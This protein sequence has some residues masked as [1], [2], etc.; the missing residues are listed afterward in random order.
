MDWLWKEHP[1]LWPMHNG[2]GLRPGIGPVVS[3]ELLQ[4]FSESIRAF[5]DE[6]QYIYNE[7]ISVKSASLE[8][9]LQNE[10]E[11]RASAQQLG[12]AG[13]P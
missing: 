13:R 4:K 12:I 3:V 10:R 5:W 8:E 6:V 7:S 1:E 9:M 2:D 11:K